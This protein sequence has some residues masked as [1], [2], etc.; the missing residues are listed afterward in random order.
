ML[1][2][3]TH[4]QPTPPPLPIPVHPYLGNR[5]QMQGVGRVIVLG[6]QIEAEDDGHHHGGEEEGGEQHG[7][8]PLGGRLRAGGGEELWVFGFGFI[9]VWVCFCSFIHTHINT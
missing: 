5:R 8:L 7:L 6:Q 9:F 1:N 3:A 2:V 4:I